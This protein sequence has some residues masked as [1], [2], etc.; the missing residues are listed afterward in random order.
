MGARGLELERSRWERGG[1][2]R[3]KG[4]QE[5][6]PRDG[7]N[8]CRFNRGTFLRIALPREVLSRAPGRLRLKSLSSN[9]KQVAT[10]TRMLA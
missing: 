2:W 9:R 3:Q 1:Y 4:Q 5:P 8:V 10:V 6:R 7:K